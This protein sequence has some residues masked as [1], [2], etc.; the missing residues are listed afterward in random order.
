MSEN[1]Q[2][3]CLNCEEP[4]EEGFQ[5]CP[6]C[7]QKTNEDLTVGV[8]FYNTISNYF[9]FDARFLKSFFPLM[10]KPGTLAKRFIQ[11]KRL[12]Y[13]H[14]AQMYLFISVVFFFLFSFSVRKQV[15]SLDE[16][17]A[18]TLKKEVVIDTITDQ[19]VKDS[20]QFAK[21]E[22]KRKKDS[23]E[24]EAARKALRAN[25]MWIGM[26]DKQ[27]DSLL[28]TDDFKKGKDNFGT[29]FSFDEEKIDSLIASGASDAEIY[30]GMGLNDDDGA[31][32]RR[33]YKQGLKFYK[34]RQGGSILPVSYTHLTL[35]TK[36]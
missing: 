29:S 13:L 12:L 2:T 27:I 33:L 34:S 23:I 18:K 22:K 24:T 3:N 1:T 19:R 11:G 16:N 30:K 4:Y 14:P 31:F 25:K 36:A 10:F 5:F 20:I 35:P 15:Q 17:L 6:H 28:Q 21:A 8:L 7:G 32:K 26:N 9:S